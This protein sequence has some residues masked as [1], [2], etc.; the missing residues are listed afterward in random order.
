M[1]IRLT[2]C[3]YETKL[4]QG[5]N[6]P[7]DSCWLTKPTVIHFDLLCAAQR[8]RE[9]ELRWSNKRGSGVE[10]K[11][12]ESEKKK[13]CCLF[14]HVW[15]MYEHYKCTAPFPPSTVLLLL[16]C[17]FSVVGLVKDYHILSCKRRERQHS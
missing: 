14:C 3:L 6:A 8:E 2:F 5:R 7:T 1:S 9:R 13:L 4:D 11:D 16:Q 17:N 12:G 10:E 15:H